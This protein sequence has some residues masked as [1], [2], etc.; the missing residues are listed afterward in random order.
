M[1]SDMEVD[2]KVIDV[3]WG[4]KYKVKLLN[5]DVIVKPELAGKM[6]RYSI[7]VIPGDIVTVELSQYDPSKG[8]IVYR[9]DPDEYK[10]KKQKEQNQ[11]D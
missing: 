2:G 4:W 6:K 5:S 11:D 10:R 7:K 8:R 9:Y 3:L 1:G